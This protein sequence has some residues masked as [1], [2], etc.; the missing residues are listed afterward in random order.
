MANFSSTDEYHQWV[1]K[2]FPLNETDPIKT[3]IDDDDNGDDVVSSNEMVKCVERGVEVSDESAVLFVQSLRGGVSV[4]FFVGGV[5]VFAQFY[6][7][8]VFECRRRVGAHI[9]R[10]NQMM[11]MVNPSRLSKAKTE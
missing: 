9:V 1:L 2:S 5:L 10:S 11:K 8:F 4:V 6:S 7:T 3:D